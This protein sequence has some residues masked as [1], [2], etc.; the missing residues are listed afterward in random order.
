MGSSWAS[1][2]VLTYK[3]FDHVKSLSLSLSTHPCEAWFPRNE[4]TREISLLSP[5][6]T[7]TKRSYIAKRLTTSNMIRLLLSQLQPL[8][9]QELHT[10]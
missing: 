4:N 10:S 3:L 1:I 2:L 8:H 5:Q 9:H 7:N 6:A